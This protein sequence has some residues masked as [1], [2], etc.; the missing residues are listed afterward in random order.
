VR[1]TGL[2]LL[3]WAA[4][5]VANLGLL[6]VLWYRR[7]ARVF[8][9]LTALITLNVG[10]TIVLYLV[11]RYAAKNSYFYTYWS[12]IVLDTTLQLCVVYEIASRVFRPLDVWAH[13]LRTS[14]VWL[15]GLSLSV[16]FALTWLASPPARTWIQAFATRGNLFAAALLSELFVAMMALSINAGLPW[17]THVAKIAQGLGAYSLITVLIES[18][19]SYF[20]AGR[21]LP[22]FTALS[23]VRMAAYLGCVTYWMINL[24]RDERPARRMTEEMRGKMFT[25]QTRL[26]YYLRDLRSR[27]K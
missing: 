15:M 21:E 3:F 5:F 18:G 8:P 25:L 7:R 19:H 6:F 24:W 14:F 10:R 11:L 17:K 23:H 1:L 27:E 12:L 20:G 2:D 16:A 4:G 22:T 9:F 26:E 13:D